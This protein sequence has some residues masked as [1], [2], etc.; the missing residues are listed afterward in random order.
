MLSSPRNI[1]LALVW[2]IV[3]LVLAPPPIL[4]DTLRTFRV[5]RWRD[6][7]PSLF[8]SDRIPAAANANFADS[9][10]PA[11]LL[12]AIESFAVYEEQGKGHV[13]RL[14]RGLSSL[15]R[16]QARALYAIGYP[17]KFPAIERTVANNGL[18]TKDL[19]AMVNGMPGKARAQ[20]D[21]NRV[22]ESLQHVARDWSETGRRERER[23]SKPVL[24]ALDRRFGGAEDGKRILV[25]GSGLGRLA[26]D[27]SLKGAAT[28]PGD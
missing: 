14:R 1:G 19:V 15:P 5:A 22:R 16:D 12:R 20:A 26:Y 8:L 13:H 11:R 6:R 2:I 7:L 25:P 24:D 3:A 10:R 28:R 17:E 23:V 9:D 4:L 18:I 27:L 21:V